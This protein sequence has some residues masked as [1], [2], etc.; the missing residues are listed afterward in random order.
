MGEINSGD[1]AFVLISAALVALMTPGLAFF[2]GGLVRRRNFLTIMMQV[3][4]SMGI[5]TFLYV[6]VGYSLS[7]SGNSLH[8]L[9]GNLD[10]AFLNGVGESPGPWAPTIPAV[11][12][13]TYFEMFAII[14]PALITGAFADRVKFKSYLKFLVALEPDRLRA[15]HPLDLG[16]RLPRRVGRSRLRRRHGRPC[17]R[18]HGG[19]GFGLGRRPAQVRQG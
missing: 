18:R 6:A 12:H 7:F 11:A 2:Y 3:F 19:P 4:I 13:F 14:T 5:V 15:V 17:Q 1:T 8:G 9:I 16:R 10:W